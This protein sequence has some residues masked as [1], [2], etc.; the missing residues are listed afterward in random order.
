MVHVTTE[1]DGVDSA[2]AEQLQVDL[3]VRPDAM[4][5]S[6]TNRGEGAVDVLWSK[7]TLVDVQG[8]ASGVVRNGTEERWA[9]P[10]MPGDVSRIPAHQSLNVFL[11]PAE[12]VRFDK[13]S[14][15]WVEQLLPVECGPIRC[16]GYHE[17]VGKTVRLTLPMQVNGAE[18]VFEWTLRITDSVKSV[19]GARPD[20]PGPH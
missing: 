12:S 13:A 18:Q 15:W 11:V 19:R 20:E 5:V 7:A 3:H 2:A 17:L 4:E 9:A 8:N 10:D 1:R 16:V 6:I 14:G